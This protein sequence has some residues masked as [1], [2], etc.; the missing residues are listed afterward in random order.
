MGIQ[1]P[2]RKKERQ[3]NQREGKALSGVELDR[4]CARHPGEIWG[5][6]LH[7]WFAVCLMGPRVHLQDV[8]GA[9]QLGL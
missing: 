6:Y 3:E 4:E 2:Q 7:L 9:F 5:F 1:T 8:A